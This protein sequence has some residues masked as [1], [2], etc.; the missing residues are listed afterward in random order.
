MTTTHNYCTLSRT[1]NNDD[2]KIIM[3]I[4]IMKAGKGSRNGGKEVGGDG[5]L[6][7]SKLCSVYVSIP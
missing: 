1:N 5:E 6:K 3:L 4:T 7:R 2:D